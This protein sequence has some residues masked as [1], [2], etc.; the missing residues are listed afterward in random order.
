MNGHLYVATS[1]G[2]QILDQPGRVN[3]IL[4]KPQNAFLSNIAFGG[5]ERD[6]LYATCGDK[7]FR[8]KVNAKGSVSW[9]KPTKPPKPGL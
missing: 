9:E 4:A 1:L 5:P 3:Q 7:V 2:I 8:R 6:L